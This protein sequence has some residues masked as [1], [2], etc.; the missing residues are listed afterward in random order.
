MKS[1]NSPDHGVLYSKLP[2]I[3]T[4]VSVYKRLAEAESHI[5]LPADLSPIKKQSLIMKILLA[6]KNFSVGLIIIK[7]IES[8]F[9]EHLLNPCLK[10]IKLKL[11]NQRNKTLMYPKL[12]IKPTLLHQFNTN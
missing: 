11:K 10:V 1:I 8:L 6:W 9:T 12:V 5:A 2:E 4:N 3:N 7:Q